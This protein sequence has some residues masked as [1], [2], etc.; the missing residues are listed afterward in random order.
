MTGRGKHQKEN[1][2]FNVRSVN[3][4]FVVAPKLLIGTD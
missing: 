4:H 2:R 1:I 3:S